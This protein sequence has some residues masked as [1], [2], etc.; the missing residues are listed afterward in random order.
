MQE[1]SKDILLVR[2]IAGETDAREIHEVEQWLAEDP[3]HEAYFAELVLAWRS[4]QFN[5]EAVDTDNAYRCFI[6]KHDVPKVFRLI[7]F[8]RKYAAAAV[9]VGLASA[10]FLFY[11]F[12][13]KSALSSTTAFSQQIQV[14]NGDKKKILLNDGTIVWLNAGSVLQVDNNFGKTNRNVYLEGEG[15]FEVVHNDGMV[16]TITTKNYTIKD[17]GTSFNVKS[18]PTESIFETAV[19]DGK[20]SV[21][22]RF[23]AD[24]HTSTIYLS[25]NNVLK[26]Q[27]NMPVITQKNQ[28]AAMSVTPQ[29]IVKTSPV[30]ENYVSWKDDM[31][32]FDDDIF[33]DIALKL[34]R[35]YQVAIKIE[36]PRLAAYHYSGS[37]NKISSIEKVLDIIKETTP[38]NYHIQSDTV[39]VQHK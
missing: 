32:V 21:E 39:F 38:I 3:S 8:L 15:Y 35:K 10:V 31:L 28:P 16:F 1:D 36:D 30:I 34:E 7:P 2:Y 22:G 14:P 11:H 27:K 6:E 20:V 19:I 26:I 4:I 13:K 5:K 25:R 37:F 17:I 18:Y 33:S 12:N 24:D 9:L 23:N 29:V